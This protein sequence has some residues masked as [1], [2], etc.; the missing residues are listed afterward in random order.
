ME[1]DIENGNMFWMDAIK[2]EMKNVRAAF[3][4]FM[5]IQIPW[6]GC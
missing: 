1:I 2:M 6:L 4:E 3:E 5:V